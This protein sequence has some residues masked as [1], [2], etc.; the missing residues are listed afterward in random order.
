MN[1]FA[2]KFLIAVF[3]LSL[4]TAPIAANA[5]Q[6]GVAV[7]FGGG[8]GIVVHEGDRHYRHHDRPYYGP[9]PYYPAYPVYNEGYYGRAPGGFYG[10]Y[11]RGHW[12]SHR[13][14]NNGVYLYF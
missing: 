6:F 2:T 4:A 12:Y 13:R 10:Y 3:G 7:G 14:W 5:A 8:S 1:S 9:R 11:S